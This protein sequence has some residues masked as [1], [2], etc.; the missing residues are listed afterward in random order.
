MLKGLA[1]DGS[2]LSRSRKSPSAR[3]VALAVLVITWS[4]QMVKASFQPIVASVWS[5]G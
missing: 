3:P 5:E 2:E 1:L 4:L